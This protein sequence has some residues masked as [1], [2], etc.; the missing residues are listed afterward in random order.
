MQAQ[1]E[2][3]GLTPAKL[4]RYWGVSSDK[5]TTWIRDGELRAVNLASAKSTRPRYMVP[6]ASIRA[7]EESRATTPQAAEPP[8]RP[9][10]RRP[11]LY[12]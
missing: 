12:V 4:A 10:D 6:W 3:A 8:P 9:R 1:H 7:F 2:T 5:I 11:K